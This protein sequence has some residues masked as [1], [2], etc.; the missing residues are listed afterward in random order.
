[1][2]IANGVTCQL[3]NVLDVAPSSSLNLFAVVF[4]LNQV[5]RKSYDGVQRLRG[6]E[7]SRRL[8]GG[9]PNPGEPVKA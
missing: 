3:F 5:G 4:T 2:S 9:V 7:S 1:M 8:K 6:I